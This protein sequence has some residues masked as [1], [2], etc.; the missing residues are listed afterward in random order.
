MKKNIRFALSNQKY[1]LLLLLVFILGCEDVS[2]STPED[3]N[4]R[5]EMRNFVID[6]SSYA[7]SFNNNFLIIP[8]NGQALITESGS[9]SGDIEQAYV[10]SIDATGREDMFY[11]YNNDDELTPAED[12]QEFLNLCLLW[13]ENNVEV[14]STDYCFTHSKMDSSYLLNEQYGFISFAANER[15]LNNIPDYPIIPFNMNV[16]NITSITEAQNF[17]YIINGDNY[18]TKAQFIAAVSDTNYD[19]IIMDLFHNEEPFTESEIT[20][21]KTKANGATRLVICYMSIGEAEDYRYY[22]QGGWATGN[23]SWLLEENPDWAGNYKV[24]YWESDWQSIIFGNADSYLFQIISAGFDG[25]YLDIIDGY[26][27]FED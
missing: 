8:Q 23:P 2:G 26:E 27:Y 24:K 9:S 14:L 12:S 17:L 6:L 21:L 19:L 11:G 4:Y 1:I 16:N 25:V 13:E 7:N 15:N 10:N 3:I 22:W 20:L 18:P 5:M